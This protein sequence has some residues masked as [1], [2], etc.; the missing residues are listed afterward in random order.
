M[1]KS[2]LSLFLEELAGHSIALDNSVTNGDFVELQKLESRITNAHKRGELPAPVYRAL[3]A[4]AMDLHKS[5]RSIL[6]LYR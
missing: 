4:L 6:N 3:Y 2:A 1:K 5:Y